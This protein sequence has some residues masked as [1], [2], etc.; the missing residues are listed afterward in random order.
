MADI[1][2][3]IEQLAFGAE[4]RAAGSSL[5]LYLSPDVIYLSE[6]HVEKGGKYV[7]DHLVRI[8]IPA[9][10]KNPAGTATMS[11]DFIGDP[12]KVAGAIRQAMSQLRW[13]SKRVRVTLSHHLGLM[14]YFVMP[15]MERRYLRTAVPLEAKKYIPIPSTSWSMT[16]DRLLPSDAQGKP[17]TRAD[18]RTRRR[19]SPTSRA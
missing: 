19:T 4:G 13:N 9:E 5:G 14:R 15:D 3:T 2:K 8:P 7:V 6:S 12:L 1:D 10:G 11:T 17:C 18:R 16:S